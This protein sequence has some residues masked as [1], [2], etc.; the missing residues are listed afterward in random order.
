MGA[1]VHLSQFATL[2]HAGGIADQPLEDLEDLQ[3]YFY[4]R[5]V[6]DWHAHHGD[7]NTFEQAIAEFRSKKV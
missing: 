5:G 7:K 3:T 2:P 4:L 6:A 1:I